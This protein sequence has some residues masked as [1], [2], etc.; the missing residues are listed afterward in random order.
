MLLDLFQVYLSVK[1]NI[2]QRIRHVALIKLPQFILILVLDNLTY[3]ESHSEYEE[4]TMVEDLIP[5]DSAY[6]YLEAVGKQSCHPR[7]NEH[8]TRCVVLEQILI[9]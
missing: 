6:F 8:V 1:I 4:L 3:G 7:L 5:E 2:V 9:K